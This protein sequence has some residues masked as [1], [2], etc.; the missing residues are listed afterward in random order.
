MGTN[1]SISTTSATTNYCFYAA[2]NHIRKGRAYIM[3]TGGTEEPIQRV[4]ARSTIRKPSF[5]A[6]R[7]VVEEQ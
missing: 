3:A 2:A 5:L 4:V 7:D 6:R 1:Y